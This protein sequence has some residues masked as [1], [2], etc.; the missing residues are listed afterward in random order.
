MVA[1]P[2]IYFGM[3]LKLSLS[4]V[5]YP[6]FLLLLIVRPQSKCRSKLSPSPVNE[7][8][9]LQFFRLVQL[10]SCIFV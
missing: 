10:F 4:P 1:N 8:Y 2:S 7:F 9:M 3:E 6:V 5:F